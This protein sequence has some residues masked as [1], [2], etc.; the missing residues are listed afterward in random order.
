MSLTKG[1][2][3]SPERD[4][5]AHDADNDLVLPVFSVFFGRLRPCVGSQNRH[6]KAERQDCNDEIAHPP[7]P[8]PDRAEGQ[9][10]ER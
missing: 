10:V 1:G 8:T 7:H 5:N 9:E 2:D 4:T 3:E 6:H